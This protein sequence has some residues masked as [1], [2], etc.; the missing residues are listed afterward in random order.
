MKSAS[1]HPRKKGLHHMAIKKNSSI[2]LTLISSLAKSHRNKWLGTLRGWRR[3]WVLTASL[4][5][6]LLYFLLVYFLLTE[7]LTPPGRDDFSKFLLKNGGTWLTV[8][9]W[10][11][12]TFRNF[13]PSLELLVSLFIGQENM[14]VRVYGR[15][16]KK[17]A[18]LFY[19]PLHTHQCNDD[20]TGC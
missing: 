18:D 3:R 8:E 6:V 4:K 11:D 1:Q 2:S 13:N 9:Y 20:K 12:G 17:R 15:A 7:N 19:L 16:G 14:A 10:S 5:V